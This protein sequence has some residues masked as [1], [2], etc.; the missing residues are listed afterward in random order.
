MRRSF[1]RSVSSGVRVSDEVSRALRAR[2]PVVALES[3]IISH[4]MPWPQNEQV[5]LEVET[6]VRECG[7]TPATV[8]VMHGVPTVGI[9]EA[10]IAELA[11]CAKPSA[12]GHGQAPVRKC[13]RR[14]LPLVAATGGH[15]ATTVSGTMLLA[16]LAGV[17]VFATGGVGGVHRGAESSMDISAD[18]TELGKTPVCVVSAGVKSILDVPRTL[19]VLETQGVPVA[20]FRADEFPAFFT[21]DSGVPSP[22]VLRSAAEAARMVA[23]AGALGMD[24][25]CLVAVPPPQA[26]RPP[27][28]DEAVAQALE[29][30][31]AQRI[32]GAEV[33]PFLLRRVRELTGGASQQL[34]VDLVKNNARV[35]AAI[36]V[37]LA[38]VEA[39]PHRASAASAAG[40]TTG[41]VASDLASSASPGGALAAVVVGGALR[42]T[43]A[44]AA[45]GLRFGG[46]L[47]TSLPGR[48]STSFG[49]VARNIAASLSSL[50]LPSV[51]LVSAVGDDAA[52][53]EL[54]AA[55]EEQGVD[56][57]CLIRVP[58]ESTP[59]YAA[60]FDSSGEL[61]AGVA[62][63]TALDVGLTAAAARSAVE[64]AAG[65]RRSVVVVDGNPAPGALAAVAEGAA[66]GGAS[67]LW[68]EPTSVEK[69]MRVVQSGSA[70]LYDV[71]SPNLEE[72]YAMAH[73]QDGAADEAAIA[74]FSRE[75][76][77]ALEAGEG[78]P[79]SLRSALD[80]FF[81]ASGAQRTQHVVCTMGSL[82]VVL[83]RKGGGGGDGGGDAVEVLRARQVRIDGNCSGA[84]DALVAG[85]VWAICDSG[86]ALPMREAVRV[87]MEAAAMVLDADEAGAGLDAAVLREALR[88][89][90]DG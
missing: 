8:A 36:A 33:T 67:L 83:A 45:G 50:G 17:R 25:G 42:D 20:T 84:G 26:V 39:A 12:D 6:I 40:A 74:A 63:T 66:R 88:R 56:G 82:G 87:G 89:V 60:V 46:A 16:H 69:G 75:V 53:R 15:G 24:T 54:S 2:A 80:R 77:D 4:G 48:I 41:G 55:L 62:D 79:P 76:K 21:A 86:G 44:R 73:A 31:E 71:F 23:A 59:A 27:G 85:A 37:E 28:L 64:A 61:I 13:S 51:R 49:G 18:L 78:P 1:L 5:A 57:S 19:E 35:A 30:A 14:D 65:G 34:N 43:N 81:A 7:A 32:S 47:G 29:E 38:R 58:G 22:M 90:G 72:L 10:E 70:A 3:T 52:G 11:A 68:F 9:S